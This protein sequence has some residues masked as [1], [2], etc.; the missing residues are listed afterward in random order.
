MKN[1]CKIVADLLPLYVEDL[2]SEETA[3]YVK[4]HLQDCPACNAELDSM[5][6]EKKVAAPEEKTPA[7]VQTVKPFKRIM[8][9][10]NRRF[11]LLAYSL[12]IFFI[13]LGFGWTEGENL[14]YNSLIMPIVGVFGYYVFRWKAIYKL[15]VLLLAIDL[16]ASIFGMIE[17]DLY[18]AFMWT[19]I[20]GGFALIGVAIAFLLHFAFRKENS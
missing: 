5:I 3:E 9:R 20:Y 16:S 2:V 15:P 10:M 14:L 11:Y 18:S 6:P 17:M 1:E 7:E 8:K 19:V 4:E 12:I 13:F